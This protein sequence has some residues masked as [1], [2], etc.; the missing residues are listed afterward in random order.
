MRCILNRMSY[1]AS[2]PVNLY[3]GVA[4][5]V[6]DINTQLLLRLQKDIEGEKDN[7]VPALSCL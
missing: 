6:G 7:C 3:I 4:N 1:L 5:L 2:I